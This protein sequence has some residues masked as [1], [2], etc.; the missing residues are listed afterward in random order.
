MERVTLQTI[1]DRLG[2][3]RTTVSNAYN[4]PDQLGD[5]LRDRILATATELGYRGPDAAARML[6]TGRMGAIGMLFTED[7]RFVFTDPDTTHFMQGVA[8]TSALSGTG[9]TMLPVP[10]GLD[11]ADT[12]VASTPVD[13][14]LV[15]SVAEDHPAL[16]AIMRRGVPIVVVDAPDLGA[17]TSFVGIDDQRGAKMAAH[18]LLDLQHTRISVLLGRV[19]GDG[20]PRQVTADSVAHSANRVARA[21]LTGY[22]NALAEAGLDP[23]GLVVWAAGGNDPDAGRR[24]ATE[25]LEAH[26]EL[27]AV[28]GFSD[29]L[30]IGAAQAAQR[31]GRSVPDDLS[32]VG[33][34]D[35]PRAATWEPPLTTVRQPL[36]DKGRAAADLLLQ[37]IEHG[38]RGR[39]ELPIEL[40]VRD[41]TAASPR[42]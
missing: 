42:L 12:A 27:T 37:Q 32:I 38:G 33:F 6:R 18:H 25:M 34:D 15:F 39:I 20:K 29:Q 26:P 10:A 13:G 22:R 4:R 19:T 7:L 8:E 23:E 41:S 31:L 1:A 9:L 40:V 36:V 2:V 30:A 24:A 21:R 16:A 11:L 5:E 28:L 17:T 3:S 35:I 14:Y